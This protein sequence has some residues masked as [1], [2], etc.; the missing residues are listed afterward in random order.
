MSA[1]RDLGDDRDAMWFADLW[2]DTAK[3]AAESGS[4]KHEAVAAALIAIHHDL[5]AVADAIEQLGGMRD[6][7]RRIVEVLEAPALSGDSA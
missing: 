7:L 4:R 1:G 5:Q 6:L 2:A 3:D